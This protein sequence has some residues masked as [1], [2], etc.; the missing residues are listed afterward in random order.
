M[1]GQE[2]AA[3]LCEISGTNATARA[4]DISVVTLRRIRS[5]KLQA[6]PSLLHRMRQEIAYIERI[7]A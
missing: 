5:G 7:Q 6:V 1:T 2:A 4:L 3:K